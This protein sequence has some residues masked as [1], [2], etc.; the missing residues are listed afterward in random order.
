MSEIKL[1]KLE[2][3]VFDLKQQIHD[4]GDLRPG[5]L[6]KQMRKS[7]DKYGAYW[8]LS[9]T[10]LGKGHTQYVRNEFMD[11][12]RRETA[13]FKRF[14][15]LL[16][17]LISISIALSQFRMETAKSAALNQVKTRYS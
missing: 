1:K 6:S 16:D 10:H 11:Q 14:R 15:R 13:N 7:K 4:I 3:L 5:S 17:R 9:Y 2:K 12:I 8:H